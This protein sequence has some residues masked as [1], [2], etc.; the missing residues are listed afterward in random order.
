VHGRHVMA[1][2]VK[3]DISASSRRWYSSRRESSM[4]FR[5]RD[6]CSTKH[7]RCLLSLAYFHL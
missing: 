6:Q 7:V 5:K 1:Q 2:A 4:S 3:K